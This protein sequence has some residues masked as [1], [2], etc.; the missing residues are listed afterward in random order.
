M[1]Y[2]GTTWFNQLKGEED[3]KTRLDG[4]LNSIS[5]RL[6]KELEKYKL[7]ETISCLSAVPDHIDSRLLKLQNE[8]CQFFSNEVV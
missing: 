7:E 6:R 3:M 8:L 5:E 1:I 2:V 4:S